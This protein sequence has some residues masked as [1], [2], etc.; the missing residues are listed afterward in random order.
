MWDV[1]R[2]KDSPWEPQTRLLEKNLRLLERDIA[3]AGILQP[4]LV[5]PDGT[6]LDGHRR[7]Y[8]ARKLGIA[9][10]PAIV[11]HRPPR[12]AFRAI[13]DTTRK[14]SSRESLELYLAGGLPPRE[15]GGDIEKLKKIGGQEL[16]YAIFNSHQS[17][18]ILRVAEM[19]ARYCSFQEDVEMMRKTIYWLLKH[20]MQRNARYACD[21]GTL[22]EVIYTAIVRDLPLSLKV[23]NSIS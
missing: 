17:P 2:L 21:T 9:E 7:V 8:C 6:I 12:E 19:I 11:C 14:L 20:R 18:G 16:L 23:V 22:P 10:I 15:V 4:I 1:A 13:N 3:E 5:Q